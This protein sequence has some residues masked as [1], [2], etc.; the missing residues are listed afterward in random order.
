M[1][2]IYRGFPCVHI[3]KLLYCVSNRIHDFVFD[4]T[5]FIRYNCKLCIDEKFAYCSYIEF[6]AHAFFFFFN[7]KRK[8][9][10]MT[11]DF[12]LLSNFP[13]H[14]FYCFVSGQMVNKELK[15]TWKTKVSKERGEKNQF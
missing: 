6:F 13:W 8:K 7:R 15:F 5:L 1:I 3:V 4:F 2:C 10:I 14:M 11:I 9:E 12:F